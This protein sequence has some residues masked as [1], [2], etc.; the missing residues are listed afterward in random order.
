VKLTKRASRG[1]TLNLA[2]TYSKT[3]NGDG[4]LNGYPYQDPTQNIS[5]EIQI[6]RTFCP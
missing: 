4:Y 3:I 1:L 6:A 5:L 2:Y